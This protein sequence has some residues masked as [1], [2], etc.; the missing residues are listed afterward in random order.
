MKHLT[1]HV[2]RRLA[3]GLLMLGGSLGLSAQIRVE[4]TREAAIQLLNE[5]INGSSSATILFVRGNL[6][7]QSNQLELAAADY[8]A[9]I[10]R[11]PEFRR[12]HQN[13]GLIE[14]QNQN[15][16]KAVKSLGRAIELG[17]SAGRTYGLMGYSY[18]NLEDYIAAENAYRQALMLDPENVDWTLGLSQALMALEQYAA[19]GALMEGM[20]HENPD[21]LDYWLFLVNV[22]I[23]LERPGKAAEILEILRLRGQAT[24]ENLELLG[25]IYLNQEDFD[26]A[27]E[28]YQDML[29]NSEALPNSDVPIY[30]SSILVRYGAI[31]EAQTL[32]NRVESAYGENLE[33]AQRLNVWNTQAQI[34]RAQ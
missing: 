15:F 32:L 4:M 7:F 2:I 6:Y 25:N 5:T 22:N 29:S 9:A 14:L 11:F 31:D 3:L 34:A 27:L 12:A 8:T 16:S 23:N 21:S 1:Q 10:Q 26:L 24:T 18:L 20:L 28:V 30:V 33:R 19:A 17:E 13:L